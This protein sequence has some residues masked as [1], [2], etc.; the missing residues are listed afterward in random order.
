[1]V[2]A[3]SGDIRVMRFDLLSMCWRDDPVPLL[4]GRGTVGWESGPYL[5]TPAIGLDGQIFLFIVW[6]LDP[7]GTSAGAVNNSGIDCVVSPDCL[8]S[9]ATAGGV[10]LSLPVTTT[11]AER[12]IAVP[13]GANLMNQASAA[14][15]PDGVAYGDNV[16]GRRTLVSRNTN[17]DGAMGS[18]GEF[19]L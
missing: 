1:M 9:L 19:P 16:L 8:R 3:A 4:S 11:T 15:R 10:G 7:R 6:R 18:I 14:V 13:L 5:N 12:V 2:A 17:L